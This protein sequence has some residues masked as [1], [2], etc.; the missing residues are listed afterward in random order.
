MHISALLTTATPGSQHASRG[1]LRSMRSAHP[2]LPIHVLTAGDVQLGQDLDVEVL[3]APDLDLDGIPV[4][5]IFDP[6]DQVAMTL[7]VALQQLVDA[8]GPVC[9]VSPGALLA[10]PL[11]EVDE[12]LGAH[13]IVLAA[14]SFARERHTVAADLENLA[15]RDAT[16]DR[17]LAVTADGRDQLRSWSDTLR[18]V[19]VDAQQRPPRAFQRRVFDGLAIAP[20]TAVA[21]ESTLMSFADHAAI[22]SQRATGPRCA[23]IACDELWG[24]A[25]ERV[26]KGS[27]EVQ[28]ELLLLNVHDARPLAPFIEVIDEAVACS[29]DPAAGP[30]PF[31]S[32]CRGVRRATDPMG[33]RWPAGDDDGFI[34][35]LYRTDAL[36]TTR[37]AHL[38]W[39][40]H[41][42]LSTR[43]PNPRR[44]PGPLRA[45]NDACA[46]DVFGADLYDRSVRPRAPREDAQAGGGG[47]REAVQWR[48][49]VLRSMV[50]G[51]TGRAQAGTTADEESPLVHALRWR[52]NMLRGL[53]PG[54]ARRARRKQARRPIEHPRPVAVPLPP[55]GFD[56]PPHD[57]T[58]MGLFRSESGLGQ[59]AR[60][61][62][63][64]LRHL[65][66][67]FSHIDTSDLYPSR[68]AVD[69]GLGPATVGAFGDV[70]LVHANAG[71][72]VAW[73]HLVFR[74]RLPGR[75]NVG[76][77]YWETANLPAVLRPAFDSVDELWVASQ[78]LADVFGQYGRVP[79]K[80][81][82][83]ASDLPD[84]RSPD[85]SAF[86]LH[87]DEFVFLFVYDA[88]SAHGRKN[89]EKALE[90]FVK[91]F[92]PDFSG[93]RFV[94]KVSNLAKFPNANAVIRSYV[95][96]YD[97]ITL[98][99]D[100]LPRS[101]V[102]DLM[103]MSDVYISLHAS[104]GYGLTLLEAMAL[105][106]PVICTGYSGNM[107]FSTTQNSWLVD[108]TMMATTE[109]TGPY[110]PG[111]IW[112]SPN[113][114][115]AADLMRAARDNPSDVSRKREH[116]IADAREA[117]SLERYA[118]RLDAELRRVL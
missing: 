17:I 96:R 28:L 112:A 27:T 118:Q 32:L 74:H 4:A 93:V 16:S 12:L 82:G 62:L 38:Y 47:R 6:D 20:G 68:N 53:V 100:Y 37:L 1:L 76:S 78:Y 86:G 46:M 63:D 39:R 58:I 5:G 10:G 84:L 106:T 48:L 11:E 109:Q 13:R 56:D 15:R 88:L 69:P 40:D 21:A 36:G 105:G 19:L 114:D 107:E 66:R 29:F 89:P 85:R 30:L 72:L 98:I 23:V 99:D 61:S 87:D 43:L 81:I 73:P 35:W 103:A 116:A 94:M 8:E 110:P 60:A 65:G 104:E 3:R 26:R 55:A 45:W 59:A 22:V 75:Y 90:A 51:H 24:M 80:V 67:E 115:S 95:D 54:H 25:T 64:A 102:L 79:V 14:R 83:L 111:S 117:A 71:E 108:Y 44:D 77:W 9:Y 50:P 101:E 113:V 92:A 52:A 2:D 31:E 70:N 34:D 57:L 41:S 49:N 42:E 97:A 33:H 18:Q 7:P 91:A